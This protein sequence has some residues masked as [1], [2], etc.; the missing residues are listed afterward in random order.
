VINCVF[1]H[2]IVFP[3]FGQKKSLRRSLRHVRSK[4]KVAERDLEQS[5]ETEEA[6]ALEVKPRRLPATE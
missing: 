6:V 2:F 3:I 5:P 1:F 4:Q